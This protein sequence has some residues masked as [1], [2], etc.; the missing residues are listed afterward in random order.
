M[1]SGNAIGDL[2]TLDLSPG[3]SAELSLSFATA[4]RPAVVYV[5]A[6]PAGKVFEWSEANN[7]LSV[8]RYSQFRLLPISQSILP[9]LRRI[10]AN[11]SDGRGQFFRRTDPDDANGTEPTCI[12]W[13]T[14]TDRPIMPLSRV[15]R[16]TDLKTASV[17]DYETEDHIAAIRVRVAD[18]HNASYEECLRR[19]P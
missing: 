4:T 16:Q 11:A 7:I 19:F 3:Q 14:A 13:S 8:A 5:R 9:P 17:F 1:T 10:S 6:D 15:W 2:Q 12:R 18:E